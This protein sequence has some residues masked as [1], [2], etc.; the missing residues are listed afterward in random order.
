MRRHEGLVGRQTDRGPGRGH[1]CLALGARVRCFY[2][3]AEL[4]ILSDGG[5]RDGRRALFSGCAID[6]LVRDFGLLG[7]GYRA[8][9]TGR[10]AV[11]CLTLC[12][13]LNVS[14]G[15]KEGERSAQA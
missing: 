2:R 13:C 10:G 3:L 7:D 12:W 14:W 5:C 15:R 8:R 1:L 6:G 4:V 9:D 11:R